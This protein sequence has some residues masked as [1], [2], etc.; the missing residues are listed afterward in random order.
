MSGDPRCRD[1][2]RSSSSRS[3]RGAFLR[4]VIESYLQ[5]TVPVDI[6]VHDNGSD[7]PSTL[8]ALDVLAAQ[9]MRIHRAPTISTA[10]RSGIGRS[11]HRQIFR[12]AA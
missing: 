3:N 11:D 8:E 6:V 4:R 1:A 5:Q 9:G 12:L 10:G 2:C 7:D